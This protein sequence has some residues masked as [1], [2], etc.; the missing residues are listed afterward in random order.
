MNKK[1]RQKRILA[2]GE[3]HNH[4]HV[5]AG[6]VD[7]D[8]SGRVIVSEDASLD[9]AKCVAD[10]NSTVDAIRANP[11]SAS[12]VY[13][14]FKIRASSYRA[15]R[16]AHV[17]EKSWVEEEQEIWTGE[18]TDIVLTPGTYEPVLQEVFDPLSKRIERVRE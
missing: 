3:S 4:A 18:H 5:I 2:L 12:D 16:L 13:A 17:K 11:E 6:E 1:E 8:P 9:Y 7:F 14:A 15:V 10:L